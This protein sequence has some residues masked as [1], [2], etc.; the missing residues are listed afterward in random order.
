MEHATEPNFIGT[1]GLNWKLFL[2][3]LINFGIVILVLWKWVFKPVAG[4]LET[5]RQKIEE[6]VKKADEIE[7]R[8]KEFEAS[9]DQ[10]F[11]KARAAAEEIIQKATTSGEA[12]KA[13]ILALAK[14]QAG[15]ILADAQASMAAE[16]QKMFGEIREEVANL[17]VMATEKILL[18]K[19]D[20]KKDK[21]M[22][23][24]IL[25]VISRK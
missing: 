12:S 22:V 25:K 9:R 1:L 24:E 18:E 6:S 16:K 11:R 14:V 19:M 20:E 3:Q 7:K 23:E 21:K 5:R 4:A 2:A 8:L 17:T 13:E 10:E 15:R